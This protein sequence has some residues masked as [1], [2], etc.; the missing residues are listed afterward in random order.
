MGKL[1]WMLILALLMLI[2][3]SQNLHPVWIRFITGPPVQMPLIVIIVGSLIVGFTIA[4][5]NHIIKT[6]RQN[7]KTEEAED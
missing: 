2:F 7:R 6:A 1:V 4:T 5:F 3:A